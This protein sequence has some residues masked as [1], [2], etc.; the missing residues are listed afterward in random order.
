MGSGARTN[1]PPPEASLSPPAFHAEAGVDFQILG[2]RLGFIHA[3]R[4][5]V[6]S[7][8]FDEVFGDD[9]SDFVAQVRARAAALAA[10]PEIGDLI[11]AKRRLRRDD[12]AIKPL[13]AYRAEELAQMQ[14]NFYGF[15][16]SYHVARSNFVHHVAPSWTPRHLCAHRRIA[17][18][19]KGSR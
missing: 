7:L 9:R 4:D 14:R 17:Q 3:R 18:Q 1:L 5:I 11:A 6:L 12:E 2:W 13:A 10:C 16:T 15:D 8:K 19:Q